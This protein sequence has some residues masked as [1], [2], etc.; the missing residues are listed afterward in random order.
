M[1]TAAAMGGPNASIPTPQPGVRDFARCS[2]RSGAL[3][4][5]GHVRLEGGALR[6]PVRR[7]GTRRPLEAVKRTRHIGKKDM[8]RQTP[9]AGGAP[10]NLPRCAPMARPHLSR[11]R[12]TLG[13]TCFLF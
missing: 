6:S 4:H 12:A 3:S 8:V 5:L 11:L 10:Q 2:A 13:T 9:L 1:I 7:T